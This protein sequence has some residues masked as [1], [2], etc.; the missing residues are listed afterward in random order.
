MATRAAGQEDRAGPLVARRPVGRTGLEVTVLGFGGLQVG[1][2]W[3]KMPQD[4]AYATISH[5]HAA[6]IRYF[7]TAP[8]YGKG[9]SEHRLGH[10]L[11]QVPRDGFVLSTKVGRYLVPE[12][13]AVLAD[14]D[15]RGLPFR[16]VYDLSYDA[17]LRAFDQS[18]QRLG[19]ARIDLLFIHDLDTYQHGDQYEARFKEAMQG[20]YPALER[21]RAEKAVGG[22]GA[23]INT[24]Q[25]CLRIIEAADLDCVM[26]AGRYTLLEQ[27]PADD[28]LP[29]AQRRGVS[30]VMGAPLN[31]G[32]LAT[33]A[34]P[35]ALYNNKPPPPEILER[36]RRIEAVCARHGVPIAAA[37][38]QFPLGH[39]VVA[40]VV[41]GM[42]GVADVERNLALMRLSIPPAF[43]A[44][45]RAEGLLRD[46]VPAPPPA[47]AVPA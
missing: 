3:K 35:G 45:M 21:L 41:P 1:D 38:L 33:G 25:G 2:Y 22:I 44:E 14:P 8:H 37:A 5:A 15:W 6:G 46:S 40:S 23:G 13:E 39:P 27:E 11:R 47:P 12:D 17:T 42:G 4:E 10:Q 31:T 7:D 20:C 36:V 30:L 16:R 24:Y 26:V 32:I 9:L 34:V 28:L 19:L 43:W 29:L 18:L